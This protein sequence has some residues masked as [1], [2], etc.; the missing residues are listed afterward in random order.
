MYQTISGLGHDLF[1]AYVAS[2][3]TLIILKNLSYALIFFK[4]SLFVPF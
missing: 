2:E 3:L 4:K 1:H